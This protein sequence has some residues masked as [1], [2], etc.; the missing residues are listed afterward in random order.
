MQT[1]FTF[2]TNCNFN[3]WECSR[4][5]CD[6]KKTFSFPEPIFYDIVMNSLKP[7]AGYELTLGIPKKTV[8]ETLMKKAVALK[9]ARD[10]TLKNSQS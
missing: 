1:D 10:I 8:D 4:G 7:L 9:I 3:C 6:M 5:D 2:A